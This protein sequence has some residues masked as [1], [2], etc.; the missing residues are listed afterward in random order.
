MQDDLL[1]LLKTT[2]PSTSDPIILDLGDDAVFDVR[3]GFRAAEVPS[4]SSIPF[5]VSIAAPAGVD[6]SRIQF[7]SMRVGFSDDRPNL[8][9]SSGGDDRVVNVGTVTPDSVF[10]DS[11]APLKW[12]SPEP[13]VITGEVVAESG[14]VEISDVVVCL[15]HGSWNIE[16]RL[17]PNLLHLWTA[18]GKTFAP[19]KGIYQALQFIPRPHE[20]KLDV[21]HGQLAFV[22]EAAL[23]KIRVTSTDER[24]LDLKLNVSLQDDDERGITSITYDGKTSTFVEGAPLTLMDGVAEALLHVT[25]AESGTTVLA[26]SIESSVPGTTDTSETTHMALLPVLAPFDCVPTIN[27]T[28]QNA[29]ISAVLRIPARTVEISAFDIE[30]EAEGVTLVSSSIQS[31]QFPQVWDETTAF[32]L[33]A[34]FKI[35]S[36]A[37]RLAAPPGSAAVL[38]IRW[39]PVDVDGSDE[40]TTMIA[41]PPLAPVSPEAFVTASLDSAAVVR[42]NQPFTLRLSVSNAH[43]TEQAYVVVQGDTADGFVWTGPRGMR[44]GPIPA[45]GSTTVPIQVVPVGGAGWQALPRISV[46]HGEGSDKREV[47]I[48]VPGDRPIGTVLVQP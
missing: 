12:I 6:I 16:L 30:P 4:G 37:Q 42:A 29:T 45:G 47:R 3:A 25:A 8:T 36:A 32:A 33:A 28:G 2:V 24:D 44:I 1:N 9:I 11:K 20:I 46:L 21:S 19:L 34:R 48:S 13:L 15:T 40:I 38:R 43:P 26:I 22:G 17:V 39:R 5:Q 27:R 23:V 14:P 31:V 18:G 7:S 10:S 35:Q 41:L